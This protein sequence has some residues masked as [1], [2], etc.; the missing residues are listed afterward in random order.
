[1]VAGAPT[2]YLESYNNQAYKLALLGC[3][4]NEISEFFDISASTLN[5]WKIEFPKFLESIKDGK[6]KADAEVATKLYDKAIGAEWV[7]EQAFKIK[8]G[9][10][11]EVIEIVKVKRTAPPDTGAASLWLRNRRAKPNKTQA[12]SLGW[13]EK[14]INEL[15]GKDG[16][17]IETKDLTAEI[18][19]HV[20]TEI[21]EQIL[22]K[23]I[24]ND[25]ENPV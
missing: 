24:T 19:Q 20:P 4:D 15:S 13:N 10:D 8:Q 6:V 3:T 9:K 22:N 7:E 14:F 21:L 5:N 16:Q 25:K 23:K 12:D 2:L 11:F 17:P 18:L 1:M